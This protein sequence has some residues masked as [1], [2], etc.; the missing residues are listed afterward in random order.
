MR[1]INLFAIG[2]LLA[3]SFSFAQQAT[4][5][6]TYGENKTAIMVVSDHPEF[7]I[8]LKSNPTTGYSWFLREYSSD[9]LSPVKHTFEAN[10]DRKIMGAPGYEIWTFH[11]KPA[12]F[13]VP[14]QMVL[15]LVYTRPWEDSNQ[16][17]QITFRVST[18]ATS[19]EE[20]KTEH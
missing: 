9:I 8:K 14:Q 7:V 11:V 16:E 5:P 17:K 4:I 2:C 6:D 18:I 19:K 20:T 13:H 1:K 10:A 3:S 15:R 12:G